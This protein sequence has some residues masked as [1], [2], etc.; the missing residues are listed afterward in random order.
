MACI[1][2]IES[3]TQVHLFFFKT[4]LGFFLSILSFNI[5]LIWDLTSQLVSLKIIPV[6]FAC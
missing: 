2:C 5:E 6:I 3:L 1:T 4:K